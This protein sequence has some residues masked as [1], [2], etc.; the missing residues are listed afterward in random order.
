MA[1]AMLLRALGC[2]AALRAGASHGSDGGGAGVTGYEAAPC[3]PSNIVWDPR[4]QEPRWPLAAQCGRRGQLLS[5]PPPAGGASDLASTWQP[6]LLCVDACPK[7]TV[8]HLQ[9][10][11]LPARRPRLTRLL[12]TAEL[13]CPSHGV[14]QARR[15]ARPAGALGLAGLRLRLAQALRVPAEEVSVG[16]AWG[17]AALL[18][19]AAEAPWLPAGHRALPL[20]DPGD[21]RTWLMA[22]VATH[23]LGGQQ[24]QDAEALTAALG[25]PVLGVRSAT[26]E[27]SAGEATAGGAG[28]G[29][30]WRTSVY[31][32]PGRSWLNGPG[33]GLYEAEAEAEAGSQGEAWLV[34][35]R[36]PLGRAGS[37]DACGMEAA[38]GAILGDTAAATSDG[39]AA[40]LRRLQGEP[41]FTALGQRSKVSREEVVVGIMV[42][43]GRVPMGVVSEIGLC[44]KTSLALVVKVPPQQVRHSILGNF[45]VR[46]S[47]EGVIP[48]QNVEFKYQVLPSIGASVP[49]IKAI[50]TG[51]EEFMNNLMMAMHN[52]EPT[53]HVEPFGW[54]A[55][56]KE[57]DVVN[58]RVRRPLDLPTVTFRP[59]TQ[60]PLATEKPSVVTVA[61]TWSEEQ[62]Q[63]RCQAAT[64]ACACADLISCSWVED[65]YTI[66]RCV[67][68]PGG[69]GVPCEECRTQP[70]CPAASC[71]VLFAACACAASESNC[72][73]DEGSNRCLEAG[74]SSPGASCSACVE[75]QHCDPPVVQSFTPTTGSE[76]RAATDIK[77]TFDRDIV[78][79]HAHLSVSFKCIGQVSVL[80]T[81]REHVFA[82][83]RSLMVGIQSLAGS[84]A[85]SQQGRTCELLVDPGTVKDLSNVPF[86]G[87]NAGTYQFVLHDV[88]PP[89]VQAI[90][91]RN[92]AVGVDLSV[93]VAFTFSE[94]IVLAPD[95]GNLQVN[96]VYLEGLSAVQGTLAEAALGQNSQQ[97]ADVQLALSSDK[98]EV[99]A[100]TLRVNLAGYLEP[101]ALY[102]ISLPSGSVT[103]SHGNAFAGL[104]VRTY[105]FRTDTKVPRTDNTDSDAGDNTFFLATVV[106]SS[107]VALC[108]CVV[109]FWR[110]QQMVRFHRQVHDE[111][112]AKARMSASKAD[113]QVHVVRVRQTQSWS[114][115]DT[116]TGTP[117]FSRTPSNGTVL[118]PKDQAPLHA[119]IS[120]NDDLES[121][122]F[123]DT[124]KS[125]FSGSRTWT[126]S[127]GNSTWKSASGTSSPSHWE[128]RGTT[129]SVDGQGQ[130]KWATHVQPRQRWQEAAGEQ[131]TRTRTTLGGTAA[132][133]A[134]VAAAAAAGPPGGTTDSIPIR[135][136]TTTRS[137][138]PGGNPT[139]TGGSS[140]MGTH[141]RGRRASAQQET[142]SP[143]SAGAG[144]SAST[145]APRAS[146]PGGST[147]G[148]AGGVGGATAGGSNAA[149]AG[150]AARGA[151][152]ATAGGS[153][154]AGGGGTASGGGTQGH[155]SSNRRNSTEEPSKDQGGKQ[156]P[157]PHAGN[158][159][160]DEQVT[161]RKQEID[162]VLRKR[163]TA[164]LM[165][166]K[167]TL[168]DL[169]LEYHPDKND[170]SHAKEIFQFI[171]SSRE[172]FLRDTG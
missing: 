30:L 12:L 75:Q 152:G 66:K 93:R 158:P 102:S 116:P 73:W 121:S 146:R 56:F 98:I 128:R 166:R 114:M 132:T 52:H 139:S 159:H 164:P 103:D 4:P 44:V 113:G 76:L 154:A 125:T 149:G 101:G 71:D 14:N 28:S 40:A 86:L 94:Q 59:T 22:A 119:F 58:M 80:P 60:R 37:A 147:S 141:S 170:A 148:A 8:Q 169:M 156:D 50:L 1:Q 108:L 144:A 3:S 127:D 130:R 118:S 107:T 27:A 92:G 33:A 109:V 24:R 117:T 49:T 140:P 96:L 29:G 143:T 62:A 160:E 68:D 131:R 17:A 41:V 162:R 10:C 15:C 124:L 126:S 171:N 63:A 161:K 165:E 23:R 61:P 18:G 21:P 81:P 84:T 120:V 7:G 38:R 138:G 105:T 172:W 31:L 78:I 136:E 65:Q 135:R 48:M 82:Q 87:I 129:A 5:S 83:G 157:P 46:S 69:A 74:S 57:P 39:E 64:D 13:G 91:P 133:T 72:R 11:V 122:V 67:S 110:Y 153:T 163:K 45:Q 100:D 99:N 150:G 104:P 145:S 51:E 34:S 16:L 42:L 88:S 167:K 79:D 85:H 36:A 168:R 111:E 2:L 155:D 47:G 25:V 89:L 151:G 70:H 95:A 77:V 9:Q 43:T 97:R 19:E 115:G 54:R 35:C 142:T 112:T 32:R 55:D 26:S 20:G 137:Q 53:R 106:G 134:G 90:A 123:N 6:Q